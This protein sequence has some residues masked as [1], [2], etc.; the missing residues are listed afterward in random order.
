[1]LVKNVI[2]YVYKTVEMK[3]N[4]KR[5]IKI[6]IKY[7]LKPYR[8]QMLR[9]N[10]NKNGKYRKKIGKTMIREYVTITFYVSIHFISSLLIYRMCFIY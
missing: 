7:N 5:K 9:I 6:K 4:V 10:V 1:M 3:K 2:Q 8:K